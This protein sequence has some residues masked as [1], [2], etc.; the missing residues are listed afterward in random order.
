MP[1]TRIY[2][3]NLTAGTRPAASVP[4]AIATVVVTS[5]RHLSQPY[6]I[7]RSS[8]YQFAVAHYAKWNEPPD[9]IVRDAFR[10]SLSLTLFKEVKSANSA[11]DGSYA[12]MIDLKQFERSDADDGSFAEIAF[13]VILH[14]PDGSTLCR[15]SFAKKT[16]LADRGFIS[17]AKGLSSVLGEGTEEVRGCLEKEMKR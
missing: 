2:S 9:E 17:L 12:L 10:D 8:P 3:L 4:D 6:I 14:A 11:P 13:D 15:N 16:K 7:Y 5:P 1:E